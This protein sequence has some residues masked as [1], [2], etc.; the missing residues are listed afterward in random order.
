MTNEGVADTQ[1][2]GDSWPRMCSADHQV[3]AVVIDGNRSILSAWPPGARCERCGAQPD[4][5]YAGPTASDVVTYPNRAIRFFCE[6]CI[7]AALHAGEAEFRGHMCQQCPFADSNQH[8]EVQIL[9]RGISGMPMSE[10]LK[11]VEEA[12]NY[13]RRG[14]VLESVEV[15]GPGAG[16]PAVTGEWCQVN[17]RTDRPMDV[18]FSR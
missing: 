16:R 9:Q 17:L 15:I 10:R 14:F 6:P 2:P 5:G 13:A 11:L 12:G 18:S 8:V 7:R 4:R 1:H 3:L